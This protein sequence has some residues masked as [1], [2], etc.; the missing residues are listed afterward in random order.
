MLDLF[1]VPVFV[2]VFRETLETAIIVSV[3]LAF[4]KQTL[5]GSQRD[6]GIYKT[7]RTQV[8]LG[9]ALGLALCLIGSGVF[10]LISAIIIT[11][12]GGA[13]LRVGKMED[14]WRTKLA[15]AIETPVTAQGKRAWLVNLFEKYA[16]FVLPFITVLREGIEGIVFVAG[17]SFSA[18]ASAVPLPVIMGLMLGGL[19]GYALY[20]GGSSAKLQY[21]LVAS[22]C[23]L[24]LVAAGLFSRAIWLFEQQQWNKIVGGDAAELGDGPGSYDIDRSIWHVNVSSLQSLANPTDNPVL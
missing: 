14:K 23:L 2:V 19:V 6:A 3:L 13:L 8:W 7:L 1:S 10:S 20:R 21:F 9:T 4:L 5:D 18:P 24:Y 22:T 16:M 11:I 15:K 17:V 12:M